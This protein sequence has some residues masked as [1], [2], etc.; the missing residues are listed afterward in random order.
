MTT[1]GL[2][3]VLGLL[4]LAASGFAGCAAPA[5]PLR[6]AATADSSVEPT[7]LLPAATP[8]AS[9]SAEL[10]A[11]PQPLA[12][13]A[14]V[15]ID[16]PPEL[17]GQ[18]PQD[19]AWQIE[20]VDGTGEVAWNTS[21]ALD[22]QGRPHITYYDRINDDLKYTFFDGIA[23]HAET[24]E[25]AGDVGAGSSLVLDAA[26]YPHI[27]YTD[28]THKNLKYAS[29]D[30]ARWISETVVHP[31]G[32]DTSLVLDAAGR[33]HIAHSL[34]YSYF[35]GAAWHTEQVDPW[36]GAWN[37]LTLDAAGR[38][39]ISYLIVGYRV[40]WLRYAYFD[41]AAWQVTTLAVTGFLS[42]GTSLALDAAGRP[43]ICY[44]DGGPNGAV[45]RY[46]V[47][48]GA[49][50]DITLVDGYGSDGPAGYYCSLVLDAADRPH[51]SYWSD[52]N[53]DLKYASF[54]GQAWQI[55]TVD[56]VGYVGTYTSLALDSQG[57]PHISYSDDTHD[58]LKY[59]HLVEC[60][61]PAAVEIRGPAAAPLGVGTL[62][63]ASITPLTAT[64]P[65]QYAWDNGAVGPTA[66]YTWTAAGTA[67]LAITATS[68]CAAVTATRAVTVYC[69]PLTGLT[70]V[71]PPSLLAG[72][73]GTYRAVSQPITASRP[74]TVTWDNGQVGPT[75]AYSW[76]LTGTYTLSAQVTNICGGAQT[77]VLPVQVLAAWPYQ[78]YLPRSDRGGGASRR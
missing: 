57:R 18:G 16:P 76:S 37:S 64:L 53:Y 34:G 45:L 7:A 38:P 61:P 14:A 8:V 6:T 40:D 26:G 56:S 60:R 71:G 3:C 70:L 73:A 51:I 32:G 11:L 46:A 22:A 25:S 52:G 1:Q 17:T 72:Q 67:T 43:R 44:G 20:T 12:V 78:L 74:L 47:F 19:L 27:S 29:F 42:Q 41:G 49:V 66:V 50:W 55:T 75:A 63:T 54:D 30:G 21:L 23:W 9:P 39:H 36:G 68:L 58:T 5:A 28:Y 59:A 62:Y 48:D 10:P 2:F 65:V 13:P 15:I 4:V 69:Q 31:G 24:V 77:A 33:P 35:D